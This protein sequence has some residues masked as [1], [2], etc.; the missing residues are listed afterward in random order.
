MSKYT[1]KLGEL[2]ESGFNV[3]GFEYPMIAGHRKQFESKFILHFYDEEI[4]FENPE[5]FRRRLMAKLND[6]M[7]YYIELYKT[8]NL[9]DNPFLTYKMETSYNRGEDTKLFTKSINNQIVESNERNSKTSDN[10]FVSKTITDNVTD[11]T[12][13]EGYNENGELNRTIDYTSDQKT[14]ENIKTHSTT[15]ETT[16]TVENS[17]QTEHTSSVA[18]SVVD[19]TNKTDYDSSSS[20]EQDTTKKEDY[21]E[22]HSDTKIIL[23][24]DTPQENF[25]IGDNTG[26]PDY[27]PLSSYATTYT[28]ENNNGS[29]KYDKD[30]TEKVKGKGSENSTNNSKSNETGN[31]T[32]SSDKTVNFDKTINS[33]TNSETNTDTE[34]GLKFNQVD[35]TKERANTNTNGTDDIES[36]SKSNTKVNSEYEDKF[37]ETGNKSNKEDKVTSETVDELIDK[38]IKGVRSQSGFTKDISNLLISFRNT[39]INIDLQIFDECSKLFMGVY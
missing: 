11:K 36:N 17:K 39:F 23:Y 34:R 14:D 12:S 1:Y 9:I 37:I 32:S 26:A 30:I 6:I 29:V 21:N 22:T 7:P 33:E 28:R 15:N 10:D 3:F 4:G 35:E 18:D 5:Q 20:N 38:D 8:E 16:E 19:K 31:N 25:V 2:H 24:S 13:H 27:I